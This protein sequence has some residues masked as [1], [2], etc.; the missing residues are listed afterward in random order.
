[1]RKRAALSA[2]IKSI[3]THP[4][5]GKHRVKAY[6][7]FIWWQ[8]GNIFYPVAKRVAFTDKTYLVAKKGMTGATGNI[9]MGLHEFQDMG[10]LL[11]FLRKEDL[12]FDIGA[13][14]GSY[15]VLAS[16]HVGCRTIA[17]EPIPATF[18]ALERNIKINDISALVKAENV[19]VGSKK[20][21]LIFT[22][23][24]DT[25][26]HVIEGL[27]DDS[28]QK[29][30]EVDVVAIDEIILINEVPVL[31]KI[32]VEGFETEV[33]QGMKNTLS[34]E[35][36]KG[37][38]IELNGSGGRYGFDETAIHMNLLNAGFAPYEY[39]PFSRKLKLLTTFGHF[40]TLYLRNLSFITRRVLSAEKISLFS[41]SF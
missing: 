3:H 5:A 20:G 10:F 35:R 2:I 25:V 38:I 23:L 41:E 32:D 4:L 9:Y 22:T 28:N 1:M 39:D 37:I 11:H 7:N 6:I 26:N 34:D 15:M 8:V 13:N 12:F 24:N 17:F 16:G 29:G 18:D 21:R 31:V 40:N 36:L 19:G 14:V 30:V 27:I 33:L